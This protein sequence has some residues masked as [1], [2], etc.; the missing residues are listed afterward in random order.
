MNGIQEKKEQQDKIKSQHELNVKRK[1]DDV[2]RSLK[3]DEAARSR[4]RAK[5]DLTKEIYSNETLVDY[6]YFRAQKQIYGR[7]CSTVD[8]HQM[9]G[10]DPFA[11]QLKA[12]V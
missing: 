9:D 7:Y 12:F 2:E 4:K 6:E 1:Q 11:S 10:Q 3:D 5:Y 8:I